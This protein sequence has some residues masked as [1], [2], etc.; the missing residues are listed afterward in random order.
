MILQIDESSGEDFD[1]GIVYVYTQ[2]TSNIEAHGTDIILKNLKQ[3]AIDQ[4]RSIDIWQ[5]SISEDFELLGR[6]ERPSYH[7]GEIDPDNNELLGD[8][9]ALPWKV[10]QSP[11]EKYASLYEQLLKLPNPSYSRNLDNYLQ[12]LWILGLSLPLKYIDTSPY[13]LKLKDSRYIYQIRNNEKSSQKIEAEN[14]EIKICELLGFS[15]NYDEDFVVFID[16]IKLSRPIKY[17]DKANSSAQLNEN[18]YFFG[19]FEPDLSN[20]GNKETGGKLKFE[21]FIKW[22]PKILPKEHRGVCVRIH[23]ASV[24]YLTLNL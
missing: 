7:I 10:D 12:M 23:G 14:Q 17:L 4:L 18:A 5:Q 22:S 19:K 1:T 2:K 21:A 15:K 8:S 9:A 3:S 24:P 11:E 13:E 16:G 6:P 20:F